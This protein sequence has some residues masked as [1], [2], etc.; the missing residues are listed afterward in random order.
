MTTART[1]VLPR[2]QAQFDLT[3]LRVFVATA[4]LGGVTKASQRMALA[5]AAASRRIQD[6]EAQFGV[7]LFERLPHGMALTHAGRSLLVHARSILHTA[8]RMQDEAGSY[9]HGEKGVVRIAA[10]KSAVLQFLPA[11]LQRCAGACPGVRIELQ[12]MNSQGVLQAMARQDADLGIFEASVGPVDCP[13]QP[14]RVDRLALLAPRDH[15]LARRAGVSLEDILSCDLIGLDEG[16]AMV[17]RLERQAAEAGRMLRMRTRVG[18]YD[19]MAAMVAQGVGLGVMPE[20][21]ALRTAGDPVL[22]CIR[23]RDTWAER[24]FSL[25]R[26]RPELSASAA[27]SVAAVL[28]RTPDANPGS[29]EKRWRPPRIRPIVDA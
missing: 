25:C 19:S 2:T 10:C 29:S 9:R 20:A 15:P 11:D 26:Q 23:I 12:E 3:S 18:S 8:A 17:L 27:D 5:P 22:K 24:H 1:P 14:Y 28:L 13:A 7:A 6:L 21:V 16:S 4:E